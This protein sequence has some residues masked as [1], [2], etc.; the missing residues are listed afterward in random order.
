MCIYPLNCAEEAVATIREDPSL[1]ALFDF[2]GVGEDRAIHHF[3]WT[4]AGGFTPLENL[5]GSFASVLSAAVT[6]GDRIDVVALGTS[7]TLQNRALTGTK[8]ADGWEDLGAFADSAPLLVNATIKP[9]GVE[10]VALF[11]VGNGG[12]VNHTT[13]TVSSDLSWKNLGWTNLVGI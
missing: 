13:R 1:F 11:V 7:D 2:L 4:A 12:E 5:G 3:M 6:G 10:E 9:A 8:R